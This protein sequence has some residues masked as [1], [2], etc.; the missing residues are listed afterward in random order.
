MKR[1]LSNFFQGCE[2]KGVNKENIFKL[3][4]RISK[5]NRS[6]YYLKTVH[7]VL[8]ILF[9]HYPSILSAQSSLPEKNTYV[10]KHYMLIPW[11]D[12]KG[13]LALKESEEKLHEPESD[14]PEWAL[15]KNSAFFSETKTMRKGPSFFKIDDEGNVYIYDCEG[16]KPSLKKFSPEGNEVACLTDNPPNTFSIQKDKIVTA[17]VGAREVRYFSLNDFSVLKKFSIPKDFDMGYS[18]TLN[19]VIYKPFAKDSNKLYVFDE[20]E[21][22]DNPGAENNYLYDYNDG[23]HISFRKGELEVLDL[24][25]KS[26]EWTKGEIFHWRQFFQDKFRNYYLVAETTPEHFDLIHRNIYERNLFKFNSFGKLLFF[27]K[28]HRDTFESF[29]PGA[30][31]LDVDNNG[32]IYNCW[33]ESD[34]FHIDKYQYL[35]KTQ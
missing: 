20:K 1:E 25:L 14:T 17:D 30:E 33:G 10:L 28:T 6:L 15:K 34:G 23:T 29:S 12:G 27:L 4:K 31:C 5:A 3:G 9:G 16:E 19:G 8:I 35:N 24:T 22:A 32:N 13:K 11:G 2:V 7:I 21:R 26:K 18:K